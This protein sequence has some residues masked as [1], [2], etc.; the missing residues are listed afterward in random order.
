MGRNRTRNITVATVCAVRVV[1]R[2]VLPNVADRQWPDLPPKKVVRRLWRANGLKP[3]SSVVYERI[4][5]VFF[6]YCTEFGLPPVSQLDAAGHDRFWRWYVRRTIRCRN[7][8]AV[9]KTLSHPLRAYAWALTVTGHAAPSWSPQPVCRSHP[10]VI[11]G[12]TRYACEQRGRAESGLARD[13]GG[14][15]LFLDYLKRRHRGWREVRLRDIDGFLLGL[16]PQLAPATVGRIA[17]A[18][19][20]WLRY[21]YATA[22]L[23]HDLAPSVVAP[24]RLRDDRPPR[25]WPWVKIKKLLRGVDP[26][27]AIGCRDRAQFLLMS[28]CGLGAAEVLQL[29]LDDI[30]WHGRRLHIVRRKTKNPMTLPL[31][32]EVARA[33]AQ[34]IRTSRPKPS[35]YRQVFLSHSIPHGPFAQSGVLRHRVRAWARRAG[36]EAPILGT[37]LLRHSHATRQ[38]VLGTAMKTLGDILGHR[39][40]ETTSIYVRSAV[41]GLRRLALP[42]PR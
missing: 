27:T 17:C 22:Q 5:G 36:V 42:V 24:V 10:A 3:S 15:E 1:H 30:D 40:P 2:R 39:D 21:L 26:T 18:L 4:L 20:S 19:R 28:A 13:V 31:L 32:P 12:Y 16:V 34:Y 37:H 41:Q 7:A 23:P 8:K 38:V 35:A 33:L 14:I 25:A 29:R 6:A 11:S 9:R